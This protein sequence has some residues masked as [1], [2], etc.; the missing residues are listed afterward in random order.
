MNSRSPSAANDTKATG[1]LAWVENFSRPGS[2]PART[3]AWARKRPNPS[4]P[5]LPRKA[6]L[7]P[8][9][10][11]PAATFAGAPPGAFSKA[12]AVARS[13]PVTVGT[14]STSSSPMQIASAMAVFPSP[15][16]WALIIGRPCA[17]RSGPAQGVAALLRG[18]TLVLADIVAGDQ[19]RR[20]QGDLL[21]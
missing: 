8:S 19:L 12:G 4:S 2:T 21:R 10:P 18:P 1:V 17:G 16:S 3:S 6:L 13:V 20:D 15:Q 14:R 5:T 11:S 9:R 7:T